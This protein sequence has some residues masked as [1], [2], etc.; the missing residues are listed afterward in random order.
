MTVLVRDIANMEALVSSV[1]R[2]AVPTAEVGSG[3]R[4]EPTLPAVVVKRVGGSHPMKRALDA[5]NIQV[6][7]YG[8]TKVEAFDAAVDARTAVH[9]MEGQSYST[10]VAAVVG[11]VTDTLGLQWLPDPTTGNDRYIFAVTLV[12][13]S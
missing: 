11:S 6:E 3:L 9:L 13:H 12:S 10:P 5:P 4:K 8:A 7:V 2:T 1:I